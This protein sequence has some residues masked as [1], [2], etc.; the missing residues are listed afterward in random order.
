MENLI[1]ITGPSCVG[2]TTVAK[3]VSQELKMNW[4]KSTTTRSPRDDDE[5]YKYI[6]KVD[7]EKLIRSGKMVDYSVV[8]DQYYGVLYSDLQSNSVIVTNLEGIKNFKTKFPDCITIFLAPKNISVIVDRL[9]NS[10]RQNKEQRLQ[11]IYEY[12]KCKNECDELIEADNS[13]IYFEKIKS[14]LLN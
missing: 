14:L 2:K 9:F 13:D 8:N 3:R 5:N 6:D 7:F 10:N 4:V 12:L 11:L 1:V